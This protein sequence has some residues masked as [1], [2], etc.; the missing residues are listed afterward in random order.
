MRW[1]FVAVGVLFVVLGPVVLIAA[2]RRQS[3]RRRDV[4]HWPKVTGQVV[5][6]GVFSEL[7]G[8]TAV[9]EF[10]TL[11]GRVVRGSVGSRV[12]TGVRRRRQAGPGAI[13]PGGPHRM[14]AHVHAGDSASF[15]GIVVGSLITVIGAGAVWFGLALG[16]A[17]GP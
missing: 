1:A 7:G 12:D 8:S 2:V 15:A 9:I 13:R 4:A 3:R 17:S 14:H 5:T 6:D 16:A 10:T 11:D